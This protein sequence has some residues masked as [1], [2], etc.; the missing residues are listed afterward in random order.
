SILLIFYSFPADM[1][2]QQGIKI[3]QMH[4]RASEQNITIFLKK[5]KKLHDFF[6]TEFGTFSFFDA[7]LPLADMRD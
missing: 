6:Y 2:K 3:K 5:S 4:K 7:P 1:R